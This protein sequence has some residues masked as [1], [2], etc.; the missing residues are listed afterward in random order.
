M[1]IEIRKAGFVNKGAELMLHAALEKMKWRYPGASFTMA[2]TCS[3]GTQPLHKVTALGI[4][5]KADLW[6][7]PF[8]CGGLAGLLP[9]KLRE[10]YGLVLENEVDVVLD[11]AGYAY[12]DHL[13]INHLLE[14]AKSCRRWKKAGKKIVLLPQAFGPFSSTK[15]KS[16]IKLV[17][18]T[19]DLMFARDPV[20]YQ[21][22]VDAVGVEQPNIR[23]APD[24]TNLVSGIRPDGIDTENCTFGIIPNCR[25]IDRTPRGKS[26][27]YLPFII[28]CVRYLLEKGKK[29]FIL[30]H[31]GE[32]DLILAKKIRDGTDVN[33]PIVIEPDPIKLKGILGSCEGTIGSR[34][35]GLVSA[36]SQGVPSLGTGW[37]HKY[38]MLF[39]DY[40]FAQGLLD[41]EENRVEIEKKIDLLIEQETAAKIKSIIL[42]NAQK[43]K[44]HTMRMWK[45]VFAVINHSSSR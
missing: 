22:I 9:K 23:V 30:V 26:Q 6:I 8:Q 21:H 24:F 10:Q 42:K 33:I 16:Y 15:S 19:A 11:A 44:E 29:P 7:Y 2:F 12:S 3:K 32:N 31:E 28:H 20:S 18:E 40:G 39:E 35:H 45:E 1:M 17:A 27:A 25:M 37:S 5:P 41:V 43:L 36:L 4:H 14:L 38:K 13:G 34:F